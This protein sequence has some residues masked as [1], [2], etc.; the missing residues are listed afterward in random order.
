MMNKVINKSNYEEILIDFLDGNLDEESHA[1]VLLFLD[2]NPAIAE[3]FDGISD[4]VVEECISSFENKAKLKVHFDSI[5]LL[6]HENYE[7]YFI[8]YHEGDL[9]NDEKLQVEDFLE[10]NPQLQKEFIS[11][12]EVASIGS[13]DL[14]FENKENLKFIDIN[15]EVAITYAEFETNCVDFVEGNLNAAELDGFMQIVD[16]NPELNKE[17]SLFRN[18]K[19]VA[20]KSIIFEDKDSLY[21][22]R[23]IGAY[24][25]KRYINSI[26]AA[27][28]FIVIFNVYNSTLERINSEIETDVKTEVLAPELSKVE[29]ITTELNDNISQEVEAESNNTSSLPIAKSVSTKNKLKTNKSKAIAYNGGIKSIELKGIEA[30]M[31]KC[32]DIEM[33][34][35]TAMSLEQFVI[36]TS[37]VLIIASVPEIKADNEKE[38]VRMMKRLK[39]KVT[40]VL[41]QEKEYIASTEPKDRFKKIADYAVKGFNK[42]TESDYSIS[43]N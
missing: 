1:L 33:Q 43:K 39:D 34:K 40:R 30:V 9:S 15:T 32:K 27:V 24:Q 38:S 26:A 12:K 23:S 41:K 11:F 20:D 22:S 4:F 21:Q 35:E 8:A 3:E 10:V 31:N 5:I 28:A 7:F 36:D 6:N 42:M 17:L 29:V 18:T 14:V 37:S 16:Q 25:V 19:I 13:D 2:E